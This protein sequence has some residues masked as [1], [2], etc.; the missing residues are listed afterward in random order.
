MIGHY[1]STFR[2]SPRNR[3]GRAT[4]RIGI[5]AGLLCAIGTVSTANAWLGGFEGVDGYQIAI[6]PV[7]N[8]NAGQYGA[9]SGYFAVAPVGITPNTGLW[10][11]ISGAAGTSSYASGHSGYDRT[12]VNSNGTSGS[13]WDQA[14]VLT[15]AHQGWQGPPLKY[16]YYLDQYDLGGVAPAS[17]GNS[18]INISFWV[19]AR[20]AGP[21]IGG[22]LPD[23]YFGD[24][25][26]FV[27]SAGNI[28]FMVGLTQRAG[29]DTVTYWDGSAMFESTIIGAGTRYDRWDITLDL[30]AQTVSADY[31]HF[32]T[33]TTTTLVSNA[34][35][36]MPMNDIEQMTFR[37]SPGTFN[38]KLMSVDDFVIE[39]EQGP[40]CEVTV[41]QTLCEQDDPTTLTLD[42]TV[43]NNSGVTAKH[44]VFAPVPPAGTVQINPNTWPNINLP[45]GQSAS[46]QVTLT[47][48]T[49]GEEV[50][51]FVTLINEDGVPCCT[52]DICI[53]PECDC[54]QVHP[55]SEDISCDPTTGE[56]TYTFQFDNLVNTSIWHTFFFVDSPATVSV[57]PTYMLMTPPVAP[58][59]TSGPI[60]LTFSG[61]GAEGG[62]VCFSMSTHGEDMHMCCVRQICIELPPCG[63]QPITGACCTPV[64]CLQVTEEECEEVNGIYQGDGT[65]GCPQPCFEPVGACCRGDGSCLILSELECEVI[66]GIYFGD[67]STCDPNPCIEPGLGGCCLPDGTCADGIS[68][69][70]CEAAQGDYLGDGVLCTPDSCP[71]EPARDDCHL[72]AVA[73]CCPQDEFTTIALTI[74]N[75]TGVAQTFDWMIDALPGCAPLTPGAFTPNA[76][77]TP[78]INPGQC[79]NIPINVSCAELGAGGVPN[80]TACLTAMVT[81]TTT[82]KECKAEGKVQM[83]TDPLPDWCFDIQHVRVDGGATLSVPG[84]VDV[85]LA[86]TARV[87]TLVESIGRA[88]KL[89]YSYSAT[90]SLINLNGHSGGQTP[91]LIEAIDPGT[92]AVLHLEARF[93][94]SR[95]VGAIH[96]LILSAEIGGVMREVASAGVRYVE[97]GS[98]VEC[99]GDLTADDAVGVPD[100]LSLLAAWGTCPAGIPGNGPL[101]TCPADFDGDGNVG[102]PDL[103]FLLANWGGR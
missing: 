91:V 25:I 98:V 83:L 39:V 7:Q 49:T 33:N 77:T 84:V 32:A 13:M 12:W 19:C 42:L 82:G 73:S 97:N 2:G 69:Q 8:Y 17:T 45:D 81:N 76:G 54:W 35:L 27:D 21:E 80:A 56:Y 55:G 94:S 52:T 44:I 79:V 58:L 3:N 34:P 71:V 26:A 5:A 31:F 53:T 72:T 100:L 41:D 43:S 6:N 20:L 30:V 18:V 62:E 88:D 57:S 50:C 78:P 40:T 29:G 99:P 15:T 64:G 28:G 74:C 14:L 37:T 93:E 66:D 102:V 60:S 103:L 22:Q 38:G 65:I 47:G 9:N 63:D 75:N 86:E 95:E 36:M 10:Q 68:P 101:S 1:S 92:S 61:L 89:L 90:S 70:E 67:G 87:D 24:E 11:V 85:N 96:D 51:F 48:L 59:G 23:G 46:G 4:R 16:R